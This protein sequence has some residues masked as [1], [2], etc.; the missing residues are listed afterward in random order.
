MYQ[1]ALIGCGQ[2]GTA[3]AAAARKSGKL[4]AV[5]D[6]DK[7]K[8]EALAGDAR[9]YTSIE[10]LLEKENEVGVVIV[11]TP[12]GYHAE[13]IIKSLQAGKHVFSEQ[14]LCLTGAAA[15]QIIETAKFS[16]RKLF[17]KETFFTTEDLVQAGVAISGGKA[18]DNAS[19]TMRCQFQG[20]GDRYRGWRGQLYPGGGLLL[21]EAFREIGALVRLFGPVVHASGTG[22]PSENEKEVERGGEV[23]VQMQNGTKGEIKWSRV[24]DETASLSQLDITTGDHVIKF[25]G[26]GTATENLD[27]VYRELVN[28]LDGSS[29]W[30]NTFAALQTVEAIEKIYKAASL[31]TGK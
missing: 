4:V 12:Q 2:A 13:H 22:M 15:W 23:S 1:F 5:C 29:D 24:N 20:K 3:H 9:V 19:F 16:R 14:P 27:P 26:L 25:T 6:T 28:G 7:T 8:A 21:Q 30:N 10:A 17:V 18:G 11:C 31:S